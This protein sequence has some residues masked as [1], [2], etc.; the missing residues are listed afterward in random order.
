MYEEYYQL[1]AEPFRLSPDHRFCYAHREYAK[2]RAYMAYAYKRAEGF[3]MITGKPGTG[4][5]TLVGQLLEEL[6]TQNV[7]VA[8]LVC[9]QL[10]ADDLLQT[11]AFGFGLGSTEMGKAEL[12]RR[13]QQMLQRLHRE[14]RRALLVVDEAQ[15][16][17]ASAME[18]LRL[19][20]NIQLDGQPLLQ[21]FLLGQ[22]ELRELI[23]TPEMEQVH[24]RIVAA[25]HLHGL[26]LEEVEPY[27]M[28]RLRMV[29]WVGD[30]A[31]SRAIFPMIHRFSGGIPRRINLICSRL[32]LHGSVEQRHAI[33]VAD[34]RVALS[35]LNEESLA[36][37]VNLEDLAAA[38]PLSET[39][40]WVPVEESPAV[41]PEAE[42]SP[43]P[44]REPEPKPV[45]FRAADFEPEPA[46][47]PQTE[48]Q[49]A[50][51]P[52]PEPKS[53]PEPVAEPQAQPAPESVSVSALD[54]GPEPAPKPGP[55]PKSAPVA[56]PGAQ[57]APESVAANAPDPDPRPAPNP[58]PP[59]ERETGGEAEPDPDHPAISSLAQEEPVPGQTASAT[60]SSRPTA[61]RRAPPGAGEAASNRRSGRPGDPSPRRRRE[62]P[63]EARR[64]PRPAARKPKRRRWLSPVLTA[65]VVVF[66]LLGYAL[67]IGRGPEIAARLNLPWPSNAGGAETATGEPWVDNTAIISPPPRPDVSG[68]SDGQAGTLESGPERVDTD[69]VEGVVDLSLNVP[70]E[71]DSAELTVAG[72]DALDSALIELRA[73]PQTRAAIRG[74]VAPGAEP[75][76]QA[77]GEDLLAA[78]RAT[79]IGNYLRGS[80]VDA[81]R[82]MPALDASR[83]SSTEVTVSIVSMEL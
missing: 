34:V 83:A 76:P 73:R 82:L 21:I 68:F 71:K 33:E 18:E 59:P 2:A 60:P 22:P 32:F 6:S 7:L 65:L 29:G 67:W 23:L 46:P 72:L 77:A 56:E 9:T 53:A 26:D 41:P 66:G 63:Q 35:E 28:H 14:K 19:L 10:E 54:T 62:R 3:V 36:V 25:S 64:R 69:F 50:P 80:G 5:S 74:Y 78:R 40:D 15:D 51:E 48:P 61:A 43:E 8:N 37:G 49:S 58:S 75:D 30:P 13:L 31:I 45:A 42:P 24:Q 79:A 11:V 27:V 38:E 39:V 17:T 4:K 81:S 44:E 57:P 55:E 47:K 52:E 70:F 20:T 16:L 12:L 1:S